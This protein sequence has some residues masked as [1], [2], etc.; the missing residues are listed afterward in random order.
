ML[1][2]SAAPLVLVATTGVS[3]GPPP[4]PD[5]QTGPGCEPVAACSLPEGVA[6][7]SGYW[8]L[9]SVQREGQAPVIYTQGVD[10]SL[11]VELWTEDPGGSR[12]CGTRHGGTAEWP[13]ECSDDSRPDYDGYLLGCDLRWS[14]CRDGTLRLSVWADTLG[15]GGRFF[16]HAWCSLVAP[17]RMECDTDF[18]GNDDDY[19][20]S[21][22]LDPRIEI[23]ERVANRSIPAGEL[24]LFG[25]EGG[26]GAAGEYG[27]TGTPGR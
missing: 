7:F 4:T 18:F 6:D 19:A 13:T 2:S 15:Y 11:D 10:L 5:E 9:R 8:H 1:R 14:V 25:A 12:S 3:C 21:S 20:Y 27:A 17:D 26:F 23:Y 16:H 24:D 22:S